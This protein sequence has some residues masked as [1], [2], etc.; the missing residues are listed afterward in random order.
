MAEDIVLPSEVVPL[1]GKT[2]TLYGRPL[3]GWPTYSFRR[4][5]FRQEGLTGVGIR[6]G[7][8]AD[9]DCDCPEAINLAPQF[10]PSTFTF[11]RP[12]A[13]RAH[14]L[15]AVSAPVPT[16]QF[17]DKLAPVDATKTMIVELRCIS[18]EGRPVQTMGPGSVHPETGET[19]RVFDP[20]QPRAIDADELRDRVCAL[21]TAVF[22]LRHGHDAEPRWLHRNE[23]EGFERST[24]AGARSTAPAAAGFVLRAFAAGLELDARFEVALPRASTVPVAERA[25][26]YVA[27]IPGS[28]G[29]GSAGSEVLRRVARALVAGFELDVEIALAIT[30]EWNRRCSPQW[31][32][33][34]LRRTFERAGAFPWSR[35]GYLSES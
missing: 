22:R 8:L 34:E 2:P 15:F 27:Q 14:W 30:R 31:T 5:H 9:V 4:E 29:R 21:A 23:G 3:R 25:A 18:Q 32:E 6:L 28:T 1:R 7:R 13:G 16:T 24:H 19:L 33:R 26:A 11:G 12:S 20:Q 17:A 10:L 35:R